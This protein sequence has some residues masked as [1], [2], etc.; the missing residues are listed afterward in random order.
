MTDYNSDMWLHQ[1]VDELTTS[2]LNAFEVPHDL[3]VEQRVARLLEERK[4]VGARNRLLWAETEYLANFVV[5]QRPETHSAEDLENALRFYTEKGRLADV[6]VLRTLP[7]RLPT[8]VASNETLKQLLKVAPKAIETRCADLQRKAFSRVPPSWA[9][10]N[11]I[12]RMIYDATEGML[13]WLQKLVRSSS[14]SHIFRGP[15]IQKI[16]TLEPSLGTLEM[17]YGHTDYRVEK[18]ED[19]RVQALEAHRWLR[20]QLRASGEDVPDRH[21]EP[22]PTTLDDPSPAARFLLSNRS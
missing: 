14:A 7:D 17:L 21:F 10:C 13:P 9:E 8:D 6:P 1:R 22:Y 19:V 11:A 20:R 4:K 18:D 2:T 12:I 5:I 16:V 3:S 15:A